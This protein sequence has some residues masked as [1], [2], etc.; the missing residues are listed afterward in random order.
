MNFRSLRVANL[1]HEELSKIIVREMEFP[2]SLVTISSVEVD[3][4]MERAIV[5]VSVIPDENFKRVMKALE[6]ERPR[7]HHIL[8]KKINIKPMPDI[9]FREDRGLERAAAVEKALIKGGEET[10]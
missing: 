6:K 5:N 7:L 2:E 10:L 8:F 3:K 9:I 1:I 4:K